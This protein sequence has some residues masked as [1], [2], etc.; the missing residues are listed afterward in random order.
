[1]VTLM[2][3]LQRLLTL[4]LPIR[5]TYET[6]LTGDN[7]ETVLYL[8]QLD[9]QQAFHQT[10]IVGALGSG[11]THLLHA[12]VEQAQ[13]QGQ[14]VMYLPL[15]E[16]E[17]HS[18]DVLLGLE[19]CDVLACDDLDLVLQQPAWNLAFFHLIN[20]FIDRGKGHFIWSASNSIWNLAVALPDLRSRLQAATSFQLHPLCDQD[21]VIALQKYAQRKGFELDI[22]HAEYLVNRV[23][24]NLSSLF[25]LLEKLESVSLQEKRRITVPFMKEVLGL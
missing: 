4:S 7:Q 3:I 10:G 14:Q 9:S 18:P 25:T 17:G 8:Q 5:L 16:L 15:A 21:K 6:F 1:M 22:K 19:S 12:A 13:R 24:R 11:K 23:D 2:A 20:A